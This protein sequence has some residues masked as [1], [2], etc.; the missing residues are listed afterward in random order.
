[1]DRQIDF[2]I[3]LM[4]QCTAPKRCGGFVWSMKKIYSGNDEKM[5][6]FFSTTPRQSALVFPSLSNQC[7]IAGGDISL[8]KPK[9]KLWPLVLEGQSLWL[10]LES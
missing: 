10:E 1:M 7:N 2:E 6:L 9:V 5:T 4:W 8:R 3:L